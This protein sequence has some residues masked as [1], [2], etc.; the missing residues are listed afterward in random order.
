M[1]KSQQSK[2]FFFT[3]L[4][5]V[6]IAGCLVIKLYIFLFFVGVRGEINTAALGFKRNFRIL[7]FLSET[8]SWEQTL[9]CGSRSS[10]SEPHRNVAGPPGSEWKS[11]KIA[12]REMV[13]S[14]KLLFLLFLR[15]MKDIVFIKS[16]GTV[17]TCVNMNTLDSYREQSGSHFGC[18]FAGKRFCSPQGSRRHE[19][20]PRWPRP[21]QVW[22]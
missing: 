19:P 2:F 21:L 1:Q 12:S 9:V 10:I 7:S 8:I 18:S 20:M 13:S 4:E 17:P 6:E 3:F 16:A 15:L 22:Q 5:Q 11:P 14:T